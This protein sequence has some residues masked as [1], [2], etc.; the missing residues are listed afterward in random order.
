[1]SRSMMYNLLASG[2]IPSVRIGRAVRVPVDELR[3]WVKARL[4]NT[5]DVDGEKQKTGSNTVQ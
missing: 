5:A 1:M 3:Q 4:D 2:Q